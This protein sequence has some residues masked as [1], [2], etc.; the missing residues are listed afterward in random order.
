[1]PPM[2]MQMPRPMQVPGV[3]PPVMMQH[4]V[5]YPTMM[6]QHARPV[7]APVMTATAL[8]T[9]WSEHFT[10]QGVRY[11]Y[12]ALTGVSTYDP[13]TSAVAAAVAQ[14][15]KTEPKPGVWMEYKDEASGQ[16]YYYNTETKATVWDQPEEFRMQKARSEVEKMQVVTSAE[17]QKAEQR[18]RKKDEEQKKVKEEYERLSL[19]QRVALFKEFLEE[20][21]I[22]PQLK[23]QDAQRQIVKEGFDEDPRWQFALSTVGQ[24]KQTYAEYCTQI[25]NKL[26]VEK[27]RQF[28]KNR[29]DF[30]DLMGSFEAT[31]VK[32]NY[33]TWKDVRESPVFFALRKDSRW[34]ALEDE[35]EK[36][37]L[38]ESFY[39]DLE[40]KQ[41]QQKEKRRETWKVEYFALLESDK[42]A[43]LS[44]HGRTKLDSELKRKLWALLESAG[45]NF[46]TMAKEV[47]KFEV[48]DWTEDFIDNLRYKESEQR[49][50]ERLQSRAMED[51]L[52]TELREKLQAMIEEGKIHAGSTW[53]ECSQ[54]LRS[55]AP[56][57]N[58]AAGEGA[59]Q[60]QVKLSER[61]KARIFKWAV[62]QL[63]AKLQEKAA[64]IKEYLV[65][66]GLTEVTPS[67]TYETFV[68]EL[69][70]GISKTLTENEPE[71]GEAGPAEGEVKSSDDDAKTEAAS[72]RQELENL[73]A[74][75]KQNGTKLDLPSFV[76]Q[77][78][79]MW[80]SMKGEKASFHPGTEGDNGRRGS[81]KRRRRSEADRPHGAMTRSRSRSRSM[82]RSHSRSRSKSRKR[83]RS[84]SDARSGS[85][86]RSASRSRSRGRSAPRPMEVMSKSVL[87]GPFDDDAPT[88]N[89]QPKPVSE[90]EEKARA[91][92]IIRQARLKLLEKKQ[93]NEQDESDLEE[94]EELEEGE[95]IEE[96]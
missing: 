78:F 67:T 4:P 3:A 8:P 49:K 30:L 43:G 15:A 84:G 69:V 2:G 28:K 32:M 58:E 77:A 63:R 20:K 37:D 33:L 80:Q 75:H 61:R 76:Q 83:S 65:K 59:S 92:E 51:R 57:D 64:V 36:K 82:S 56:E 6:A 19:E 70:N 13:P 46:Q 72:V 24:K 87:A 48:Y 34:S 12:N 54:L 95:T 21:C 71:E 85:G 7:A 39:R 35:Q 27:R 22:S 62:K 11:F 81:R 52:A 96:A 74:D 5:M 55:P 94:G 60:P 68:A 17:E 88:P 25:V 44:L 29:E 40:R 31:I 9:G 50:T 89:L 66:A 26:A 73:V 53:Q 42:A 86:S 38:F 93:A 23:W 16:M 14:Q 1:M 79:S 90:A 47:E 10:P 45:D 18:A 41:R 91:E